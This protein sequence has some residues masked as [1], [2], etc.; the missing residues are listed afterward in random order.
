V[1]NKIFAVIFLFMSFSFF[2]ASEASCAEA[3]SAVA[4]DSARIK[5][6]KLREISTALAHF[7]AGAVYDNFDEQEKALGEYEK[8]LPL[9]P[10]RAVDVYL[11]LGADFLIL[12]KPDNAR[13]VLEKAL[14]LDE[15]NIKA[16]LFLAAVY[17][18]KGEFEK[19]QALHEEALAYGPENLKVLTFLSDLFVIQQEY[20]KAA[21]V[22]EKILQKNKNDAFL[23]FNLG[24]IYGKLNLL[25]EAEKN[26]TKAIEL[27]QN[28]LEAQMVLGFIYEIGAKHSEAVEQYQEV[29]NLDSEF[30][31]AHV[32]LGKLYERLNEPDKALKQNEILMR[33]EKR[34]PAPYLRNF[35]INISEKK[36]KEAEKVLLGAL[37]NGITDG[38]IYAGLGSLESLRKNYKKAE[39][40]YLTA[41]EKDPGN[42]R[43]KLYL[44]LILERDQR[45]MEAITLLENIVSASDNMPSAL[46]QLGYMYAEEGIKLDEAVRI[47]KKAVSA[48]PKN[49]AYLDSLGW[50]YFKKNEFQ[51]ARVWLEKAVKYSPDDAIIHEHLGDVY[52]AEE[53]FDKAEKEWKRA[54]KLN[55]RGKRK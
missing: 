43:F 4:I 35:G 24:V 10:D 54:L 47:L 41:I 3:P 38:I 50:A 44:A 6:P 53:K 14:E 49:G 42:V 9:A 15:R 48:E 18:T 37:E 2:C 46:N 23:Y 34:S 20:D 40:Y 17:T 55:P 12:E 28:Y 11:R 51:N 22:Y 29:I 39:V 7:I 5:D 16:H 26:L 25:T 19:A 13:V 21:E 8:V 31:E 52:F 32:R 45:R 33:M 1:T 27:D 30:I 36:Y